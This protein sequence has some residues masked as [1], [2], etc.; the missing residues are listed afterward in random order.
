MRKGRTVVDRAAIASS[1][2]A[3]ARMM[4]AARARTSACAGVTASKFPLPHGG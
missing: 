4:S 1:S 3:R 2:L